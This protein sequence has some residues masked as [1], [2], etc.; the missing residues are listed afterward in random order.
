M[1]I[2]EMMKYELGIKIAINMLK[3]TKKKK[4]T[5]MMREIEYK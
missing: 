3:E 5:N 1:Q 2:T 4:N